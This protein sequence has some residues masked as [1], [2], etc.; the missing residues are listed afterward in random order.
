MQHYS[1]VRSAVTAV[2]HYAFDMIVSASQITDNSTVYFKN[3]YRLTNYKVTSALWGD[4]VGHHVILTL[5]RIHQQTIDKVCT[6]DRVRVGGFPKLFTMARCPVCSS[7]CICSM[8]MNYHAK[9]SLMMQTR[10]LIMH[11][12]IHVDSA[13]NQLQMGCIPITVALYTVAKYDIAF[14]HHEGPGAEYTRIK[15]T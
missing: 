3:I 11:T 10:F 4:N 6:P 5:S 8:H 15:I 14:I 12:Y 7:I 13:R 2:L 1:D 9:V